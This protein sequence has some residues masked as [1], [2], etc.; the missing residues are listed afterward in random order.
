M[1]LDTA[2]RHGSR[3]QELNMSIARCLVAGLVALCV[4]LLSCGGLGGQESRGQVH[5]AC[6]PVDALRV[7][8]N[9]GQARPSRAKR[10][11]QPGTHTLTSTSPP[12]L[13]KN[14][15]FDLL[16]HASRR[17]TG[18][19]PMGRVKK[20]AAL[21]TIPSPEPPK[22]DMSGQ[23]IDMDGRPLYAYSPGASDGAS[24]PGSPFE[25]RAPGAAF[26]VVAPSPGRRQIRGPARTG[27]SIRKKA[28][29]AMAGSPGSEHDQH[30]EQVTPMQQ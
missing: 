18:I 8:M 20:P 4:P 27:S 19:V 5:S 21:K 28:A 23:Q 13:H 14:G 16:A 7:H 11:R 15:G 22:I 30:N 25:S 29:R 24:S 6:T 1:C 9:L 2:G 17:R 3:R 26:F 10:P 12:H